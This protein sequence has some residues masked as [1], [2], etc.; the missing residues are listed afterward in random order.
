MDTIQKIYEAAKA[1]L[2]R[3]KVT[4]TDEFRRANN[5]RVT[6]SETGVLVEA[7]IGVARALAGLM[8]I[9]ELMPKDIRLVFQPGSV[10]IEPLENKEEQSD[11][12]KGN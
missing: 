4:S 10:L 2:T 11:E 3:N 5:V 1:A 7:N 6:P 12:A 9:E 8:L